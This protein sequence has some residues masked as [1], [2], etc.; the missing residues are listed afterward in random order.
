MTDADS[1]PWQTTASR[2]MYRNPW[3]RVREDAVVRPGGGAGIYGVVEVAHP[4]VFVVALTGNDEVVLVEVDRY[5][6]GKRL[7]EIPAGGSDGQDPL[8]AAQRELAEETGLVADT[9]QRLGDMWS[10]NGLAHAEEHVFLARGLR[11]AADDG[12]ESRAEEGIAG[13]HLVPWAE[14][15]QAIGRGEIT[16]AETLAA[17][18]LASVALARVGG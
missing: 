12:A 5:T 9:W 16:D 15:L 14:L 17:L 6:I 11:P 13:V 4:A 7:L 10:L 18:M 2:E 1:W 3:M 8:V